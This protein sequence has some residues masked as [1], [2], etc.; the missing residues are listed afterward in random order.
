MYC[1]I[2]V[3]KQRIT[4]ILGTLTKL[5]NDQ[6]NPY[7]LVI[8]SFIIIFSCLIFLL[9]EKEASNN[10]TNTTIG[11]PSTAISVAPTN[12]PTKWWVKATPISSST[13]AS[14]RTTLAQSESPTSD[15]PSSYL[16]PL[17]PGIFAYISLTPPLPNRIRMAAG[18]TNSYVG[19]ILPGSGVKIIDGPLCADGFSWWQVE[20]ISGDL[21]GWTVEGRNTE[22]WITPCPVANVPCS[23]IFDSP[24]A[25]GA[26]AIPFSPEI[27][28]NKG[29]ECKSNGFTTNMHAKVQQGNLLVIRSEP[30]IGFVIGY[31]GPTAIVKIINGPNCAGGVIWW[32]VNIAGLNLTGWTTEANLTPCSKEECP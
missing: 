31:A 30:Y 18:V 19:Q 32:K 15:C 6:H 8:A 2:R 20:T 22:Q 24:P 27:Y 16:S 17:Y 14:R 12:H 4:T 25:M 21:R 28:Q 3:M 10:E 5:I 11:I 7:K 1:K 26:I 29:T 13:P 23:W 9:I